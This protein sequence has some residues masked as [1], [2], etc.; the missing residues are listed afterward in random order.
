[1]AAPA[2]RLQETPAATAL[3]AARCRAAR[4]PRRT[5]GL[6]H[7]QHRRRGER[8]RGPRISGQQGGRTFCA[9]DERAVLSLDKRAR[10]RRSLSSRPKSV[11]GGKGFGFWVW[12]L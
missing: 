5:T 7:L 10:W 9:G 2:R 12:V 11:E 4:V 1:M 8:A 6:L 3:V